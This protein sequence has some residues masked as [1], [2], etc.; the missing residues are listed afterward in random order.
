MVPGRTEKREYYASVWGETRQ[1]GSQVRDPK[2]GYGSF[3]TSLHVILLVSGIQCNVTR[4][5]ERKL[6]VGRRPVFTMPLKSLNLYPA[7]SSQFVNP[8]WRDRNQQAFRWKIDYS[9][10]TTNAVIKD[11]YRTDNIEECFKASY[12][13]IYLVSTAYYHRRPLTSTATCETTYSKK[14]AILFNQGEEVPYIISHIINCM[15]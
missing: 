5:N 1:H 11:N 3:V 13:L 12:E 14:C 9:A 15:D 2:R 6:N 8:D 10:K 7:F 4:V